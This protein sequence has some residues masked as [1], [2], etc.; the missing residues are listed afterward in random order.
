ML[1]T[2][3]FSRQGVCLRQA[4]VSLPTSISSCSQYQYTGN[5]DE[6]FLHE[7]FLLTAI[8][9]L[10]EERYL[11]LNPGTWKAGIAAFD[12]KETENSD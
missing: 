3:R 11:N 6:I 2:V 7:V 5:T 4:V 10:P 12:R 8:V 1:P 9:A